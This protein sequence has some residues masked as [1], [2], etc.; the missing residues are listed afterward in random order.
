[1]TGD[2]LYRGGRHDDEESSFPHAKF[3]H[4]VRS[5]VAVQTLIGFPMSKDMGHLSNLKS[6]LMEALYCILEARVCA[7]V[8]MQCLPRMAN[9]IDCRPG[10]S[11]D[12]PTWMPQ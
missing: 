6:R 5:D 1:M 12:A 11:R 7:M 8:F 3:E 10:V 2:H 4:A 9:R